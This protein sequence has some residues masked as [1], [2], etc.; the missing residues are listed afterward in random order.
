MTEA[1]VY[2]VGGGGKVHA[3]VWWGHFKERHQ[4]YDLGVDGRL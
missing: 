2:G 1:T 4:L 3:A